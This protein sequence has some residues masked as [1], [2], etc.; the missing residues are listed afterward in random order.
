MNRYLILALLLVASISC[1]KEAIELTEPTIDPNIGKMVTLTASLSDVEP[2]TRVSVNTDSEEKWTFA[3][4]DKD[5]ISAWHDGITT[6]TPLKFEMSKFEDKNSAF[7]G[8]T[9]SGEKHRFIY[10]YE[11]ATITSEGYYTI[12]VSEQTT[13][14]ELSKT[15]LIN[16]API[17]TSDIEEGVVSSLSMNHLGAIMVVDVYL[18]NPIADKTYRLKGVKYSSADNAINSSAVID[19]QE[20]DF[21][22]I[23]RSVTAGTITAEMDVEFTTVA[24]DPEFLQAITKLNMLPSTVEPGQTATI[25]LMIEVYDNDNN[26]NELLKTLTL[27]VTITN[28]SGG[29]LEFA[30]ATHNF[31]YLTVDGSYE[32]KIT[33]TKIN[34]WEVV[35]SGDL[36][37]NKN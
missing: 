32:A 33:G 34:D 25:E 29:N 36:P 13:G 12:D 11:T 19:M 2:E 24:D 16:D 22:K 14:K 30:R 27:P 18:E 20:V 6:D 17:A 3:W 35:E 4:D 21:E 10:P 7:S 5:D 28:T 1:S 26:N 31:T 8:Q 23:Y 15:Y 37:T 9:G